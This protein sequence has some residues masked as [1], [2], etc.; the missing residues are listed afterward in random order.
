MI[1]LAEKKGFYLFI[2]P[3]QDVWSRFT[4]GDG[5]PGWTLESI[6][7]DILKLKD[8]EMA[9]IHHAQGKEYKKMIWPQNY[10]D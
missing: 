10:Q 7:I 4:G 1:K 8:A 9:Y 5:A 3:H 2:D 6:G